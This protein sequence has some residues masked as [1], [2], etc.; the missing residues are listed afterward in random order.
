MTKN[1]LLFAFALGG[2][3]TLSSCDKDKDEVGTITY[4]NLQIEARNIAS[5]YFVGTEIT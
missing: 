2:I 1:L 3:V 5:K 4:S